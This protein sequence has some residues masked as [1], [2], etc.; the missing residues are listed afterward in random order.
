MSSIAAKLERLESRKT[1]VWVGIFVFSAFLMAYIGYAVNT[2]SYGHTYLRSSPPGTLY[3]Q[4][5]DV[6]HWFGGL[7][8]LAFLIPLT[9]ALMVA[10]PPFTEDI[11]GK[12]YRA[13]T[14]RRVFHMMVVVLLFLFF[15]T[16]MGVKANDYSKANLATAGNARNRANDDRWCCVHYALAPGDCPNTIACTPGVGGADLVVNPLFLYDFWML[17]VLIILIILAFICVMWVFQ[18]AVLDYQIAILSNSG[19]G[20]MEEGTYVDPAIYNRRPS[21]VPADN[22]KA[23]APAF[24]D[25]GRRLAAARIN[26]R[27]YQQ[28]KSRK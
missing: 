22:N 27:Q 5:G 3:S 24:D 11:T 13:G 1:F 14:K 25:L 2:I 16:V 9:A 8:L 26:S 6:Y 17:V 23:S 7:S 28:Y 19:G 10:A 21:G 4:R 20:D 15:M 18:P 12:L